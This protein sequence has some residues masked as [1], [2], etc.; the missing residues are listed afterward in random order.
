MLVHPSI[1]NLIL[2]RTV[3]E[4]DGKYYV[5]AIRV[6]PF[7][8]TKIYEGDS[9]KAFYP[10]QELANLNSSSI[11]SSDIKRFSKFARDYL[12]VLP[13]YPNT[14]GDLRMGILPN[15]ITPL[16]GIKINTVN[17]SDHV[18]MINYD[19]SLDDEKIQ[20]FISMLLGRDLPLKSAQIILE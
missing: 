18:Q 8:L 17:Q 14:I 5:Q 20:T 11:L 9:I 2:W 6:S 19:R 7:S 4:S 10:D 16:W 13:E 3:Y 1:G 12:V 15:S